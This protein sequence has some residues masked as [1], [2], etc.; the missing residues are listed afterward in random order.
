MYKIKLNHITT[1]GLLLT[2]VWTNVSQTTKLNAVEIVR[3]TSSSSSEFSS[4]TSSQVSSK[5]SDVSISST[6]IS[7]NSSNSQEIS[8]VSSLSSEDEIV[9]DGFKIPDP[10][11]LDP[12]IE[13][14]IISC[15]RDKFKIPKKDIEIPFFSQTIGTNLKL[16][17]SEI[18][19]YG[20]ARV[21]EGKSRDVRKS[22]SY[23]F[24]IINGKVDC[25]DV[26][27]EVTRIK[28]LDTKEEIEK[29]KKEWQ[30]FKKDRKL[31]SDLDIQTKEIQK[32]R[33]EKQIGFFDLFKPLN[34]SA[35]LQLGVTAEE[36]FLIQKAKDNGITDKNQVAY[37]LGTA[38]YETASLTTLVE[39]GDR[40][41]FNYLEGRLDLG[42]TLPGDGY[43][44]RGRGYTM[45]TGKA[46][47]QS[48]KD[49]TGYDIINNPDILISDEN[50]SAF[51]IVSGMKNGNFRGVK[52]NDYV[53]P[54]NQDYYNA[55]NIVNAGHF[56]AVEVEDATRRLYLTD[57]RIKNYSLTNTN[58]YSG[59]I[60]ANSNNQLVFDIVGANGNDQTPVK[61]YN[62]RWGGN[63][64]NQRWGYIS[65][66]K[67]IKGMN[68][69]CLD[70]GNVNDP[71]NR[72]L[73]ISTCHNGNNQKWEK[74]SSGRVHS[75]A[76]YSQ[77][78]DA[79]GGNVYE[80][81]TLDVWDCHGGEG[82]KWNV[83]DL[84]MP[85][86][87]PTSTYN[88]YVFKRTG[89][90]QCI[91]MYA[92]YD[93]SKVDTWTCNT[94]DND[95][96]FEAIPG[97]NGSYAYR[98]IG[99][100]KCIDAWNPSNG[101]L[102]YAWSCDFNASNHNWYYDWNTKMLSQRNTNQCLA[103]GNPV[104]YSRVNTWGCNNSDGNLKWDAIQV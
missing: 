17:T 64:T 46:N 90:N 63:N 51:I 54:T 1:V 58:N 104:N 84:N 7:T 59:F 83:A 11:K 20:Y 22:N 47:Y 40:D 95:Q 70:A 41:Y 37:I 12:K 6:T 18:V 82:Q 100:N 74:D 79:Y 86:P 73:R 3:N 76:N 88:K 26:N 87:T 98:K 36:S 2:L 43:K 81:V 4:V 85:L 13:K 39:G 5:L 93:G 55:R 77:C 27:D 32:K 28:G 10:V 14:N 69:K 62:G 52:L 21:K 75:L 66:T 45:L 25:T 68:N 9:P 57:D 103:R 80:G 91:N 44:Y 60:K 24:N 92:P 8:L 71:N 15:I 94:G 23:K 34:V 65:G 99:T 48:F 49:I 35:A 50:L 61:L 30:N 102:V 72:W 19:D 16:Q 56:R 101:T 29:A 67:E 38:Y 89:T 31:D 96:I 42:N 33:G 53:T 78:M 97:Q